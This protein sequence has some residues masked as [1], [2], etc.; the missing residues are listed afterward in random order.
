M[1]QWGTRDTKTVTGTISVTQ[2]SRTVTGVGTLFTTELRPGQTLLISSVEYHIAAIASNT[3]LTLRIP[4]VATSASGL[5]VTANEQP[6]YISQ[7]G[8]NGTIA[9][10]DMPTT[11]GISRDEAT[12]TQ[13]R[14]KGIHTPGWVNYRTYTDAQGT[15]RN[16]SHVLVA[17]G[18]TGITGDADGATF[19]DVPVITIS[20][21][22][23]ISTTLSSGI[24]LPTVP[25]TIN[26]ASAAAFPASGRF[27]V[28]TSTGTAVISYTGKTG[29]SFTGCA[30]VSGTG[31][32]SAGALIEFAVVAGSTRTFSVTASATNSGVLSYQ[33]Q[34]QESTDTTTWTNISGATSASF[35][36]AATTLSADPAIGSANN[37][38]K[39]R[40]VVSA[41]LGAV[42][43]TSDT[44]T[45]IVT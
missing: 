34:K 42:S 3:S 17:F 38:D 21:Q 20:S 23:T 11:F 39:Y 36:T 16:K 12:Q 6:A 32:I 37:G 30:L 1:S 31:T 24:T 7:L 29:T 28:P 45:L 9:T 27:V 22:P 35:A 40:V 41:T 2:S 44:A 25:T 5:T 19:P 43:V 13:N 15:T 4:Y 8:P 26:V 14:A 33:W 10:S 18:G